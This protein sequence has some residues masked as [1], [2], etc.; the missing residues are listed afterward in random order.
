MKHARV[1]EN[2]IA[3]NAIRHRRVYNR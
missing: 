3:L 1:V 2:V